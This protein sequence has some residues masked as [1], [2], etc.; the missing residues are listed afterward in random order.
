MNNKKCEACGRMSPGAELKL[1]ARKEIYILCLNCLIPF[2][3]CNL[4]K[5]Q[6]KSLLAN[7]HTVS[8]FYLHDDFYD[9]EGN[10]LQPTYLS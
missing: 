6:F 8:E 2:V 4:S 10:A 3:N 7:G 1:G 9:E 5:E